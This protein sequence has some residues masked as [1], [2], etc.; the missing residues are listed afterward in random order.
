MWSLGLCVRE[1]VW[2]VIDW[3]AMWLCGVRGE[4]KI[5]V[6]VLLRNM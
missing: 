3:E 5:D 6:E 4:E 2:V 1:N